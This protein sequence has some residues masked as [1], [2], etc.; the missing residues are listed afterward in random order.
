LKQ[1]SD[2]AGKTQHFKN[3]VSKPNEK[4]EFER[5]WRTV[6]KQISITPQEKIDRA[7]KLKAG[8]ACQEKHYW[9]EIMKA[10]RPRPKACIYPN[11]NV[12]QEL[13]KLEQIGCLKGSGRRRL[14]N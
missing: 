1:I 6:S 9:K 10:T 8:A 12:K 13:S 7:R 5:P 2:D 14:P 11:M 3:A 4:K